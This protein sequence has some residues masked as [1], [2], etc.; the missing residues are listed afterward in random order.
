MILLLSILA[1]KSSLSNIILE[2]FLEQL[3]NFEYKRKLQKY[4]LINN[5]FNC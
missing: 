5:D 2:T 3:H 1:E 4:G